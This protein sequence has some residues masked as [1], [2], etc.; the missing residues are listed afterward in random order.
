MHKYVKKKK[1]MCVRGDVFKSNN[2]TSLVSVA[3]CSVACLACP[4]PGKCSYSPGAQG[5]A[6]RP[7]T[8]KVGIYSASDEG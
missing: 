3:C 7:P 8:V 5:S 4:R 6:R 1:K 2:V